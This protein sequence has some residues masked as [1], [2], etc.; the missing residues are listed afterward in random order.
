MGQGPPIYSQKTL[1][2]SNPTGPKIEVIIP[3]DI[4]ARAYKYNSVKYE[5]LRAVKEVLENPERIFWGVREYNE[6][7]WC[8][9]GRP[10]KIY[11]AENKIV[12]F[13][14]DK[15]FAVYINDGYRVFDWI[16]EVSD[17]KDNLNPKDWE[18]RYR[19]L[20]WKSTS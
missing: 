16:L 3:Y 13:P 6:G 2:P 11:I 10:Q 15:V 5:N 14:K 17:D 1:D 18:G 20:V 9:V 7:G 4:Y 8:Y 12:D 19:S